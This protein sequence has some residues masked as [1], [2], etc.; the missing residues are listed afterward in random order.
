MCI[1]KDSIVLDYEQR[2][3][4]LAF[5]KQENV[6]PYTA[7]KDSDTGYFDVVGSHRRYFEFSD[8]YI[9]GPP[10]LYAHLLI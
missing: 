4:L 7:D 9:L 1:E 10:Q 8:V 3:R 2:V 5:F 6:G